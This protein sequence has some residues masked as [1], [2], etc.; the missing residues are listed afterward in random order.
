MLRSEQLLPNFPE[1]NW[2]LSTVKLMC[3][4]R[5]SMCEP[6]RIVTGSAKS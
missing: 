1:K 4:E 3:E 6:A 5:I 2:K